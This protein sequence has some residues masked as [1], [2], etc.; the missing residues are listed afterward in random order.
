M[1]EDTL[2]VFD[3]KYVGWPHFEHLL[4][5][6]RFQKKQALIAIKIDGIE[7]KTIPEKKQ[8]VPYPPQREKN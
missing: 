2:I 4:G 3:S 8:T 6:K 5:N 7:A 1:C